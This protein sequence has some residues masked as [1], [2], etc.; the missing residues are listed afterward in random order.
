[1][2]DQPDELAAMHVNYFEASAYCHWKNRRL[3]TEAEWEYVA[4]SSDEFLASTGHV[5]EWTASAFAPY[6]GFKA[7]RYREYSEPWFEANGVAHQVL[8]GGSFVTHPRLKY[9]QY[10]N[11]YTP[12]R[13]DMFCGFRTCSIR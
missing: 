13:N 6:P 5:W 7:E 8:K 12:E 11:F 10:R 3:P 9:P 2:I 4:M 1:M